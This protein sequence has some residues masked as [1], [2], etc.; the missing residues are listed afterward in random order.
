MAA[1]SAS[2]VIR[3]L[4]VCAISLVLLKFWNRF[5]KSS[6]D[7]LPGPPSPSLISG[8]IPQLFDIN[9]WKYHRHVLDRYGPAMKITGALGERLLLTFDPKALHHILVKDQ[10]IYEESTGF[11]IRNE[12][13]FG[14]GLLATL[15]EKHRKQ[16]KMMNPVFSIN[17]MRNMS[18]VCC[19]YPVR[20]AI[21]T[22]T[23]S[24]TF[25]FA[26]SAMSRILHLLAIHTEVQKRL[27]EEIREAQKDGQLT[28]DQLVSLPY[29]NAVCRETLRV[30][31]FTIDLL[32]DRASAIFCGTL[33]I[34]RAIVE[35][36]VLKSPL[37]D[38]PGPPSRSW[39]LGNV[40]Q[41]FNPRGWGFH[42]HILEKFG[43]VVKLRGPFG[44]RFLVTFD[45]KAL[46]HIFVKDQYM[47][48]ESTAFTSRNAVFFGDGL[49]SSY[50]DK[51]KKQRKLL[52][53][54]FSINHMREMI[55]VFYEVTER[56]RKVL[57]KK[58]ESGPQELDILHWVTRTALELIAQSGMGYSFDSL[59]D[60]ENFHPYSASVKRFTAL[61][62]G[63]VGFLASRYIFPLAA[64]FNFPR[65]KRFIVKQ[66][67]SQRVRD[68]TDVVDIM[69]ST[70]LDIIKAK[71][72][73][74]ASPHPE[75]A[76]EIASKKDIISILMRANA[77]ASEEE[78]MSDE[79]VVGQVATL[80]FAGMD[81]TS[82]ALARTLQLLAIHQGV[83]ER[84]RDEVREAQRDGQLTYDQLV[85]LPFLDA[86][87]RETLRV[88]PPVNIAPLRTIQSLCLTYFR[89][90]K[91]MVLPLSKPIQDNSGKE[92]TE[93]YIKEG[94]NIAVSIM[95]A[96]CD[97]DLWGPDS[98]EWKP[99]RWLAPLPKAVEQAH[100]PGIYSH[101]MTF[102]G[103]GR[104]CIG[105]KFSQLEMKVVLSV[106]MSSFKFSLS[107]KAISWQMNGIASPA[108]EG[109]H[110]PSQQ[111]LPVV[112]SRVD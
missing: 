13:C 40:T 109:P 10:Y 11:I 31:V 73:A 80:V 88:Y 89:A 22:L 45:P 7:I 68:L 67:P 29:L 65:L 70:S 35:T 32:I 93:L 111:Q 44:E 60:D 99:E 104:A 39:L 52:N 107:Q 41:L 56:L 17:H 92:V 51:H 5:R 49:L 30:G 94:T 55:P 59:E 38:I 95:G 20:R 34:V 90:R 98:H 50:G 21:L 53:P 110:G 108:V 91:D 103:G 19:S 101:L 25:V 97:P 81:T 112:M 82:S 96:N 8:N 72:E 85:S 61:V 57:K 36:F 64:K 66:I 102:L 2:Q 37:D 75:V 84:L 76:A 58:L 43:R 24:R 3:G 12:A 78:R 106:L 18:F 28:Y 69:H 23:T 87:C 48:E 4:S 77:V 105:F 86:V 54:V 71:Q 27:R 1:I 42:R 47:Y 33:Y 26:S 46:H 6:L 100:M 79:E 74:M 16:R 62:G 63:P 15:G 9:G 83:Q 14:E